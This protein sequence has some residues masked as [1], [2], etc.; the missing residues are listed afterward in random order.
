MIKPNKSFTVSLPIQTERS[1]VRTGTYSDENSFIHAFLRATSSQ[2]RKQA[3][4]SAHVR[5]V[6]Q[7][8]KTWIE[9]VTFDVY[10]SLREGKHV[11]LNFLTALK[12]V[13]REEMEKEIQTEL[14]QILFKIVPYS[15]VETEII[16]NAE[17]EEHFYLGF[18][19]HVERRIRNRLG[20]ISEKKL[21]EI[22]QKGW[23]TFMECFKVAHDQ[24][25]ETFKNQL[26]KVST[27][28]QVECLMRYANYNMICLEDEQYNL[29]KEYSIKNLDEPKGGL[30][31]IQCSE[32]H[33]EILGELEPTNM[34]NRVFQTTDKL[35]E[36]LQK[37]E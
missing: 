16:P 10:Q 4:H 35:F 23:D 27:P 37:P 17:Q 13:I 15:T 9:W 19:K 25:F 31:F 21:K 29:M 3:S 7:F 22:I 34:I 32:Q 33:F 36:Q 26:D 5:L 6:E 28:L 14:E 30:I 11:R 1:F 20:Q 18:C 24:A 8:K 12:Q 2:Y